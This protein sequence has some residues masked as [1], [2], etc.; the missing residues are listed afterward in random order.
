[1]AQ[2]VV[3]ILSRGPHP[4]AHAF[5]GGYGGFQRAGDRRRT[6]VPG[7]AQSGGGHQTDHLSWTAP[8]HWPAELQGGPV[9]TLPRVVRSVPETTNERGDDCTVIRR[10]NWPTA[11]L[12]TVPALAAA[13]CAQQP[14]DS[15]TRDT[16]QQSRSRIAG[17]VLQPTPVFDSVESR[18]FWGYR[19]LNALHVVTRPW[20]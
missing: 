6:D 10:W 14:L 9:E 15:A 2:G 4:H 16:G 8:R 20:G 12:L 11:A 18:R 3:S 7:A 1:M 13:L 5:P 19:V 17:I